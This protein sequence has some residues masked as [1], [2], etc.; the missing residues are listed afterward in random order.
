MG[1]HPAAPFTLPSPSGRASGAGGDADDVA[2]APDPGWHYAIVSLRDDTNPSL[3]ATVKSLNKTVS[4][5]QGQQTLELGADLRTVAQDMQGFGFFFRQQIRQQR[6]V[7]LGGSSSDDVAEDVVHHD[8]SVR[9]GERYERRA[10]SRRKR[11]LLAM[12]E[13]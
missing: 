5:P 8:A 11:A 7:S 13:K 1:R 12:S 4:V 9:L 3:E 6:A 2:Q 10:F